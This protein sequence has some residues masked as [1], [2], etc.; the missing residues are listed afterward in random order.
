[1]A[2]TVE[3]DDD[4]RHGHDPLVGL[5]ANL[6]TRNAN[7]DRGRDQE[8]GGA[9]DLRAPSRLDPTAGAAPRTR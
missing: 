3:Q 5:D 1:M 6:R 8:K 9:G 7:G 4:E 2:S